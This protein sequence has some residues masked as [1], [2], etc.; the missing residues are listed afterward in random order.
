MAELSVAPL[1]RFDLIVSLVSF[2]KS[3]I[4]PNAVSYHVSFKQSSA[5]AMPR[6]IF[7]RG[8][9]QTK[10]SIEM[11]PSEESQEPK[12]VPRTYTAG[13]TGLSSLGSPPTRADTTLSDE[14]KPSTGAGVPSTL[15]KRTGIKIIWFIWDIL[16]CCVPLAFL[17]LAG[18]TS[19]LSGEKV[20]PYGQKIIGW[21][22]L[23]SN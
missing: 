12:L 18:M 17:V 23:V 11:L 19:A 3:P 7:M 13:S 4:F 6:N 5:K 22:L 9:Q 16:L 20:S 1:R 14:L 2:L 8:H 21:S 15:R 10:S